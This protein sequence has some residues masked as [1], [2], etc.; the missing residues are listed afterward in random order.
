MIMMTK[1]AAIL[2]V[3]I[4]EAFFLTGNKHASSLTYCTLVLLIYSVNHNSDIKV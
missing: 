4:L 1:A 3:V 2:N